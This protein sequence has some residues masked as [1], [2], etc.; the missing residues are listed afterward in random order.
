M[1]ASDPGR[2]R[3]IDIHCH[4]IVARIAA[5]MRERGATFTLPWSLEETWRVMEANGIEKGVLSNPIPGDFFESPAQATRFCRTANDAVADLVRDHPY[6]FG[7]LAAVPMPYLDA[8]LEHTAYVFD[9]L[10][11]D[12][13]ILVPHAGTAY[14][15]DTLFD[16][17]LA[18][19][20]RRAAV[21]L[22]HPLTPPGGTVAAA[23]PVLADFL[24]DTTRGAISLIR[25]GAL[26]RYPAISFV[27]AHA[28]GFLPY[29]A[30]RIGVLGRA[31]YGI[32]P[33]QVARALRRFYYDLA[34]AAPSALPSLLAV[35]APDRIL[36][37][38][39]WCAAPSE[40]VRECTRGLDE[41]PGV[42]DG[43]HRMINR[44][45]ALRLLPSLARRLE[46]ARAA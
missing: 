7:L 5:L 26:D 22:V 10:G 33:D 9:E 40:A 6:R 24:L 3:R 19:L 28:G 42:A 20:D 36:Y 21:V 32:G 45:N 14:L 39:D 41:A 16:P 46:S 38:T 17:L 4:A 34:L 12:G 8:A 43:L 13:V 23:P 35:A 30:S 31:F 11:A 2:T 18:E 15:G 1:D 29:A 44:D 25:S 37:G 27:L